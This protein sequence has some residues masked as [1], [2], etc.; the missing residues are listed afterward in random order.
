MKL[1][2]ASSAHVV[3]CRRTSRQVDAAVNAAPLFQ[4]WIS[5][6]VSPVGMVSGVVFQLATK[7][8]AG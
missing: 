4:T 5:C 2:A 3:L 6:A 8:G 1:E 7:S